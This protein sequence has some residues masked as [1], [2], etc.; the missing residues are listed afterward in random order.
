MSE[1][2]DIDKIITA[3]RQVPE[4]KL[5]IIE[6]ANSIPISDGVFDPEVMMDRQTDIRLALTEAKAYG[7]ATIQAVDA[8]ILLSRNIEDDD[9]GP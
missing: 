7:A 1:P 6:I 4:K 9:V 2:E 5:S 8:L 3:L